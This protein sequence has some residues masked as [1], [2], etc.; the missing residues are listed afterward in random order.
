MRGLHSERSTNTMQRDN[1]AMGD[2]VN[3]S[4][5]RTPERDLTPE[6]IEFWRLEVFA[7]NLIHRAHWSARE[8]AFLWDAPTTVAEREELKLW[9]FSLMRTGISLDETLAHQPDR[10]STWTVKRT[11][12]I[13]G[14]GN[15]AIPRQKAVDFLIANGCK[16]P[17]EMLDFLRCPKAPRIYARRFR[18]AGEE[19]ENLSNSLVNTWHDVAEE[20]GRL[21][22]DLLRNCEV[23]ALLR[24]IHHDIDVAELTGAQAESTLFGDTLNWG[25]SSSTKPN[26]ELLWFGCLFYL[27]EYFP[28]FT[29]AATLKWV[30][31]KGEVTDKHDEKE[32]LIRRC[33]GSRD[34]CNWIA[35]LLAQ[36]IAEVGKP[37]PP[38]WLRHKDIV[39]G[40]MERIQHTEYKRSN[41]GKIVSDWCDN[42][43]VKSVA[44]NRARR[45][46]PAA[47]AIIAGYLLAEDARKGDAEVD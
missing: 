33:I 9:L 2:D 37:A 31:G 46:D 14:F 21:L 13:E 35:E 6:E 25:Q 43:R 23:P 32:P 11:L 41:V 34:A 30:S 22:F 8:V 1:E 4:F 12:V 39:V 40:V 18:E 20:T 45:I 7:N 24:P 28:A 29:D 27:S 3:S 19:F 16:L 15:N 26:A 47:I 17:K 44:H 5:W 36:E 10:I 42:G 38:D